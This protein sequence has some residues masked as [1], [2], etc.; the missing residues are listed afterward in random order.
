MGVVVLQFL[1]I[2][3]EPRKCL[4]DCLP[5]IGFNRSTPHSLGKLIEWKPGGFRSGNN[6]SR[7]AP[8]SL[9]KLIEWKLLS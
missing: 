6:C 4:L 1:V 7:F 9:G 2:F 5:D 3:P 8:H